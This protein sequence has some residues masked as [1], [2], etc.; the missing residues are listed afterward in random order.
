MSV[1]LVRDAEGRPKWIIAL[2]EDVT[3]Q[4]QALAAVKELNE[5]FATIF[6]ASLVAIAIS[7]LED[8]CFVDLNESFEKLLGYRRDEILGHNSAELGLWVD[9]ALRTEA[10]C[11]LQTDGVV[12]DREAQFR[13]KSGEAVDISYTGCRV[14]IAGQP[15]M[16]GML[17][18]IRLQKE[19]RQALE[20]HRGQLEALVAA[21][22][23][24]LATARDAAE[25]ATR[26]KSAFLA[27]MSHEIRSPMN[28]ILGMA[29]V[30]RRAGVSPR[31]AEQLDKITASCRHLLGIINDIL[32]LSKIEAGKLVLEDQEF[33][34]GDMLQAALAPVGNAAAAK[35]LS[36]YVDVAGLPA[37]LRGDATRLSQALVNYLGNAVK[38][39]ASGH[40]RLSGQ[41]LEGGE[42]GY[43][44]RFEVV[45]SGIGLS[46]EQIARLFT[47]FEQADNS[48]T[49]KYGGTGLGL[50]I[51]RRIAQMMGGE[52]GVTSRPGEGSC[53]W[54]TVRVGKGHPAPAAAKS[55][56]DSPET[57]L[58][59]EHRGKRVLLAE[60][61]P[62]NQLVATE[63]LGEV[64]LV[65][66]IAE[67]GAE[68][69]AMAGSRDY[70]LIL[71]D[72]QMPEMDGLEATRA[73]RR[74]PRLA[75]LPILAMTAN[76][77]AEDREK[78]RAAGMNDFIAKPVDPELLFTTVLRWLGKG[79]EG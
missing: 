63:L 36:L 37:A 12:R 70:A 17:T 52:V 27:N 71:M 2:V 31:Q 4:R 39:T 15:H 78:C 23:A 42:D 29:H 61:E 1:S 32:D 40:I 20:M 5:R 25:A 3:E 26:A 57:L 18:D 6:H 33:A 66:E 58:L 55:V 51:N 60:D 13:R 47:A 24:E 46:E 54:L 65:A 44:L 14:D 9:P 7:R 72:M 48:T 45:D 73:I 50:A 68:A 53:F 75:G 30:M 62:I 69:L 21:R 34:L 41:V 19:A 74:I 8:G 10:L 67:N 56:A 35:G 49:R 64:G 22:T 11:A 79:G 43:L 77:F 16:L 38:F 28:G 76:A 59:R